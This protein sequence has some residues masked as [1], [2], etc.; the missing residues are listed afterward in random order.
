MF[1]MFYN[2]KITNVKK[3][4]LKFEKKYINKKK[5]FK[6]K[7]NLK[8]NSKSFRFFLMLIKKIPKGG[9]FAWSNSKKNNYLFVLI[10]SF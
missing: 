3:Y 9:H 5:R 8:V 6:N 4:T 7:K 10:H 2:N 1:V